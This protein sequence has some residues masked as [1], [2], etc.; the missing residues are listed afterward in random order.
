MRERIRSEYVVIIVEILIVNI[1]VFFFE[2]YFCILEIFSEVVR[3]V[4]GFVL[5]SGSGNKNFRFLM[6]LD[7][8]CIYRLV[9]F[10]RYL[11]YLYVFEML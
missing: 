7:C 1:I 11:G 8:V 9:M 3:E 5:V 10:K 6:L 2:F 4:G